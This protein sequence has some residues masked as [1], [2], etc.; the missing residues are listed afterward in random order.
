MFGGYVSII[1]L[2]YG[3]EIFIVGEMDFCKDCFY[4]SGY[5]IEEL[6]VFCL[7]YIV[8]FEC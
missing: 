1:V 5:E 3:I 7:V 6:F 8:F 4:C 2:D